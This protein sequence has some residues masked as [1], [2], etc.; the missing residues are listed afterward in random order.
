MSLMFAATVLARY[1]AEDGVWPL[2]LTAFLLAG[3]GGAL[4]MWAG[5]HYD[6]LHTTLRSGHDVDHHR[7]IKAVTLAAVGITASGLVLTLWLT[8]L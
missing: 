5:I 6:D 3:A 7:L 4:L 2:A 8:F 1:A